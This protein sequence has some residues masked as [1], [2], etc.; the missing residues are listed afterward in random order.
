MKTSDEVLE[1][2]RQIAAGTY[3][4]VE[5]QP[6]KNLPKNSQPPIKKTSAKKVEKVI[7]DE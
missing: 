7:D 1:I 2:N 4:H 6:K 3:V 5:E